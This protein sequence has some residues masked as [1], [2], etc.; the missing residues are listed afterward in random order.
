[1]MPRALVDRRFVIASGAAMLLG[2]CTTSLF[3]RTPP[4][5]EEPTA[6]ELEELAIGNLVVVNDLAGTWGMRPFKVESIALVTRQ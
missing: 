6:L 2:G 1:M 4:P 5:V 3:N